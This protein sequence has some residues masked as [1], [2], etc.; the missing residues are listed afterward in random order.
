MPDN[1]GEMFYYG[2]VPWHKKG[3]Q[4]PQPATAN[5]AIEAGGLGWGVTC[6]YSNRRKA[7]E[8]HNQTCRGCAR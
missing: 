6:I 1:V 2:E 5:E 4:L 3:T 8:E 7:T